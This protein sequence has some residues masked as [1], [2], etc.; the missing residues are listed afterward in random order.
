MSIKNKIL[1][2][3]FIGSTILCSSCY[4]DAEFGTN[5]D[6]KKVLTKVDEI[7]YY[8]IGRIFRTEFEGHTYIIRN[9]DH[10]GG[11]CHDPDCPCFKKRKLE[12]G[13]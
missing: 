9:S 13:E 3:L 7:G 11:I 5:E 6:G 8:S 4:K 12:K 10:R 1:V 2:S